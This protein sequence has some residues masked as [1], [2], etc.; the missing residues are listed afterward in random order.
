MTTGNSDVI[1]RVI[2]IAPT[3]VDRSMTSRDDDVSDGSMLL[4][5]DE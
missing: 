3:T 4:V 5:V 1:D 2:A